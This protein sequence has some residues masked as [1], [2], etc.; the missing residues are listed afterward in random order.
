[1][2]S[3][4]VRERVSGGVVDPLHVLDHE[5]RRHAYSGAEEIGN[6]AVR[7]LATEGRGNAIRFGRR[8]DIGVGDEADERQP[9]QLLRRDSLVPKRSG[10]RR[11]RRPA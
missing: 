1:M 11:R 7:A 3:N 8:R 5:Q 4:S 2:S 9:W 6:G 10:P